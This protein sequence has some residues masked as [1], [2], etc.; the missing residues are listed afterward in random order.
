MKTIGSIFVGISILMGVLIHSFGVKCFLIILIGLWGGGGFLYI[1]S[2]LFKNRLNKQQRQICRSRIIKKS[3]SLELMTMSYY[4]AQLFMYLGCAA[5][6]EAV[7][8]LK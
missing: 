7:I 5:I 1:L 2:C 8:L 4:L 3:H 6:I